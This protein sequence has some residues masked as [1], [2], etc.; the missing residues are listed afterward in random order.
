MSWKRHGYT[1]ALFF[2]V[3]LSAMAQLDSSAL[4]AKY[5]APLDREIFHI[6][7]GFDLVVDYGPDRQVCR[8]EV[9]S[10]MPSN[11]KVLRAPE[12]K[13]RMYDFLRDLVPMTMRGT[14][15][16]RMMSSSGM[17]SVTSIEYENVTIG[18]V[19]M[20]DQPFAKTSITLRFK[21]CQTPG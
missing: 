16:R 6:P 15:L 17:A 3:A 19:S 21:N 20:A 14:E 2:L 5:G 7:Q 4:R 13:Q 12:M 1:L 8:M 18:E 10:L 11:E 9:P